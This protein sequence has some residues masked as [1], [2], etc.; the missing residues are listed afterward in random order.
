MRGVESCVASTCVNPVK[1]SCEHVR[2]HYTNVCLS[3]CLLERSVQITGSVRGGREGG[4][5]GMIAERRSGK[6]AKDEESDIRGLRV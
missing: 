1:C 4:K 6:K 5:E 3:W 2:L